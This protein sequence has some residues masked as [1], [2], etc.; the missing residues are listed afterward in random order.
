MTTRA[1]LITRKADPL[2]PMSPAALRD[3]LRRAPEG[4]TI[5]AAAVLDVLEREPVVTS[6]APAPATTISWRER[7]WLCPA[8]T[9]LGVAEVME[10]TGKGKSWV[11]RHTSAKSGV[12]I[13]PHRKIDGELVF[14]AGEFRTWLTTFEEGE[15][16]AATPTAAGRVLSIED[17]GPRRQP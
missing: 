8:E 1:Q 11:Y 15:A 14:R 17:R 9:R 2:S 16:S 13:I 12:S 3:W 7:L 4:T 5:T 6:S 10:A